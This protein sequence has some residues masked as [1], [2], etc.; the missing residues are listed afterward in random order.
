M[1]IGLIQAHLN[2]SLSVKYIP[3]SELRKNWSWVKEG[4]EKVRDKGHDT[5]IVEDIYCDCYEERS[6]LWIATKE[7]HAVGFMVLQP[8]GTTLH[9]WVAYLLTHDDLIN[10]FEHIKKIAK[11][12]GCDKLTFTSVRKGWEVKARAMGFKPSTWELNLKE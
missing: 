11:Q 4:L 6:M 5:W 12:G 3:P 8:M 1:A 9:V 10:G 7:D 2:M